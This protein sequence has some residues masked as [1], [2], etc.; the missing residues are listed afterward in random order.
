MSTPPAVVLHAR[1]YSYR[2]IGEQIGVTA[3]AVEGFV[4][5]RQRRA[6]RSSWGRP[7][8]GNGGETPNGVGPVS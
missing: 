4:K 2:R 5:Y 7:P 8:S 3:Q 6:G 1:G